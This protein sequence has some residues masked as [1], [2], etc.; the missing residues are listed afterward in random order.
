MNILTLL[1]DELTIGGEMPPETVAPAVDAAA[2][3]PA[4]VWMGMLI[5]IISA[6]IA[7]IVSSIGSAF[8]VK[9]VAS[10]G[11]G[12]M[13]EDPK[14]FMPALVLSLLPSTQGI[15]GFVISFMI[16][17]KITPEMQIQD[18]IPLLVAGLV[19]G[20]V[21]LIS[22]ILQG[23][24]AAAGISLA[25]KQPKHWSKAMILALLVEMFALLSFII[26]IFM[27]S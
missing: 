9:G 23:K 25:A 2:K 13:S 8:A 10:S 24:V 18:S 15:Y 20:T 22:A 7:I 14:Q 11:L 5:A 1:F 12:L 21:G 26:A 17:G 6:A 16:I 27:L 19:I 4:P 3:A